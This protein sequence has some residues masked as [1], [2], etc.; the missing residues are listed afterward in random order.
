VILIVVDDLGWNDEGYHGSEIK[1]PSIV[2]LTS[3]G[4]ELNQF[5]VHPCAPLLAVL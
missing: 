1:T 5:Y 2:R 4:V 3:E